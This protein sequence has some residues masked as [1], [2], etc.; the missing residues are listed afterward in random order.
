MSLIKNCIIV[1]AFLSFAAPKSPGDVF[2][3]RDRKGKTV[4][5]EARMVGSGQGQ[6]VLELADGQYQI[7]PQAAVSKRV[8][9][10][11]PTPL[12]P[13]AVLNQLKERFGGDDLFRGRTDG[14]FVVG[15]VPGSSLPK[16]SEKRADACLRKATKFMKSVE[17]NFL[18]FTKRMRI[19]TEEP[20]HPLVVLVFESDADFEKYHTSI[21]GGEGMSSGNVAGFYS[22]VSNWLVIRMTECF[23]FDTP[24]HEAIHQQVFNQ[25]LLKRLAPTPAWFNEGIAT[26]FEGNGDSISL[27]PAKVSVRYSKLANRARTVNWPALVREDK[28]FRG[29]IFAGEAYTHAWGMHWL[30][31]TKYKDEYADYVRKLG[32]KEPLAEDQAKQRTSDFEDIFGKSGGELQSEFPRALMAAVKRQRLPADRQKRGG[33]IN[34]QTNL[35]DVSVV[36]ASNGR[37]DMTTEGMIRNISLLRPMTF[38]VVAVT[39]S[40]Q[41]AEWLITDLGINRTAKLRI[42]PATKRVPGARGG[43][44]RSFRLLVKSVAPDSREAKLWESGETPQVR[45]R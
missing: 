8:P 25:H 31:V 41:Y 19:R 3:Y 12:T 34:R 35:A 17:K 44:S 13:D 33:E 36:G 30:L 40:G 14:H 42:Q 32:E 23:T 39:N 1:L 4:T 18:S 11:P 7:V 24:L 22:P 16:G 15:L 20:T 27:G 9:K 2:T 28:A 26:G 10:D 37:G 5:V 29:D 21:S 6:H 45:V 38:H 43:P